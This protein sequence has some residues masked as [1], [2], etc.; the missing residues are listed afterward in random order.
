MTHRIATDPETVPRRTS[1][2]AP[3]PRRRTVA[4]L[5]A[6]LL[7]TGPSAAADGVE[8]ER[9][10]IDAP[11]PVREVLH[12]LFAD[13][14]TLLLL[15]EAD[16]RTMV[17]VH[18]LEADGWR[19]AHRA[20][21]PDG[22]VLADGMTIAARERLVTFDGERLTWLDP[23]DWSFRVLD[24]APLT[25][26]Y[27]G[28]PRSVAL[29]DIGRDVNGDGR[30]DL[31]LP[32]FDG[33]WIVLQ[34]ET[35]GSARRQAACARVHARGEPRSLSMCRRLP[36]RLRRRRSRRSGV[37]GR[38]PG[39]VRDADD[40]RARGRRRTGGWRR[41]IASFH[42]RGASAGHCGSLADSTAMVS[43]T[44]PFATA[45]GQAPME[46]ETAI[47]FHFGRREGAATAF[48][49]K[50]TSLV[51]TGSIGDVRMT[52]IDGDGR[53]DMLAMSGEFSV[54][55]LAMA[56]MTGS[57]SV[58]AMIYLM[59]ADGF[60][61]EP[62]ASRKMKLGMDNPAPALADVNAMAAGTSYR[63]QRTASRYCSARTAPGSSR[64]AL[65]VDAGAG[66]ERPSSV[67]GADIDRDGRDDLILR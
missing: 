8:F 31:A 23:S 55:K 11:F 50:P 60:D 47:H 40:G 1:E 61:D 65:E 46:V 34:D 24:L 30:D 45:S 42:E 58:D 10:S 9:H 48:D 12:G 38:T 3:R 33:L 2:R 29:A 7:G 49:E 28:L 21:L 17:A 16:D 13:A 56:L 59:G 44:S 36:A 14:P 25:T 67:T 62:T 4:C 6:G 52:D 51:P 22:A 15:G 43:P 35:G 5:L 66:D 64:R 26:L 57:I 63:S 41:A 27:R 39:R 20:A 53:Q 19:E 18:V 32:D 37:V 54:G